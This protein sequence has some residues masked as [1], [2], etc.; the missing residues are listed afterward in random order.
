[1][2][3]SSL[4]NAVAFVLNLLYSIRVYLLKKK[5]KSYSVNK[6]PTFAGFVGGHG[7]QPYP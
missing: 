6:T 7:R 3:S 5:K 4:K 2:I 1:M